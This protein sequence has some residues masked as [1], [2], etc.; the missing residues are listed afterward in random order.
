MFLS[1]IGLFHDRA[2]GFPIESPPPGKLVQDQA[3]FPE[4][5]CGGQRF[6]PDYQA[7]LQMIPEALYMLIRRSH[8]N[9]ASIYTT[10]PTAV[11]P[12]PFQEQFLSH[13]VQ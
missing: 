2:Q 3:V 7:A 8:L 5:S 6:K 4:D 12:Q 13:R 9:L 1:P 11:S 10:N